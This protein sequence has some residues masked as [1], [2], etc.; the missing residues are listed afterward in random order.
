MGGYCGG[1]T[2]VVVAG[3]DDSGGDAITGGGV[4]VAGAEVAGGLT[5]PDGIALDGWVVT[6]ADAGWP[7]EV[8]AGALARAM[9]VVARGAARLTLTREVRAAGAI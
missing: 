3:G 1:F 4:A 9:R 7:E 8:A 2:A 5:G 6:V